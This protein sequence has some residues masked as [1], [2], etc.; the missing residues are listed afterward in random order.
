[1][2]CQFNIL[3][4]IYKQIILFLELKYHLKDEKFIYL[5]FTSYAEFMRGIK[6]GNI[7]IPIKEKS[8]IHKIVR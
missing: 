4:L 7:G 2:L 3:F 6:N 8:I 5:K 1:M